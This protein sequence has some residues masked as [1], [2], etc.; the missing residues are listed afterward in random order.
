MT[1][2]LWEQVIW[3]RLDLVAGGWWD[4]GE[5]RPRP[6]RSQVSRGHAPKDLACGATGQLLLFNRASSTV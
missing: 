4:G 3:F 6:L 5:V 1:R 2:R